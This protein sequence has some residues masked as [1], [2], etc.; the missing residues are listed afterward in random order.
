[1]LVVQNTLEGAAV[2]PDS[3]AGVTH[4]NRVEDERS[5]LLSSGISGPPRLL[6][7]VGGPVLTAGPGGVLR[8]LAASSLEDSSL[9]RTDALRCPPGYFCDG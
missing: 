4:G 2:L 6:A 3:P 7:L 1:M 8:V 5:P 9:L